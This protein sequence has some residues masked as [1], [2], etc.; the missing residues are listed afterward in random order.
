MHEKKVIQRSNLFFLAF[1][2][3]V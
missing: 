1:L 3:K 2:I